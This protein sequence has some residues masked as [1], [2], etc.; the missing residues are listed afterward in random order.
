VNRP[1]GVLDSGLGGLTALRELIRLMPG[2]DFVYFGDTG[3][4]PYGTRSAETI[5]R[6]TRQDIRFLAA[7]DLKALVVACGT[8]SS[9]AM[10][11]LEATGFPMIGV[12]G[13][14]VEAAAKATRNGKIG[15]M[16][17]TASVRSGA[18][19]RALT[20]IQH[21]AAGCR[22]CNLTAIACPLLVPL[23]ENGRTGPDDPVLNTIL[24]EYLEPLLAKNVDTLILGCTHYPHIMDA[25]ASQAPGTALVDAG[26][27]AALRCAALMPHTTSEN[28][29]KS[30]FFVSDTV[31][32]FSSAAE[33]FLGQPLQNPVERVEIEEY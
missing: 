33:R 22:P 5:L 3:R 23:I 1:I 27:E 17:T 9:V 32:N 21:R 8:I 2:E 31:D 14:A 29:G 12:V 24:A 4:V 19:E 13:P 15:L 11:A 6:F 30:R 18:Y 7:F 20:E 26:R 25:I 16:A 10:P 28:T